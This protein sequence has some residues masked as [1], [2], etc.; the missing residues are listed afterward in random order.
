VALALYA[1]VDSVHTVSMQPVST[2]STSAGALRQAH[3]LV[4][5]SQPLGSARPMG[6]RQF[7]TQAGWAI[8]LGSAVIVYG[9]VEMLGAMGVGVVIEAMLLM[10]MDIAFVLD[11][12][13]VRAVRAEKIMDFILRDFKR[14]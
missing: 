13:I 2:S 12:A 3:S 8:T 10:D 6:M 14:M 4:T 7:Q 9:A 5:S 11:L 1:L